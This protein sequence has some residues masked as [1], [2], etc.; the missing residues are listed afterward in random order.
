VSGCSGKPA[1]TRTN[2]NPS[3]F[4]ECAHHYRDVA[5]SSGLEMSLHDSTFPGC[6]GEHV[7]MAVPAVRPK[8]RALAARGT[9]AAQSKSTP[10]LRAALK[11]TTRRRVAR[12][13]RS[14][15]DQN[16][17]AMRELRTQV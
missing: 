7:E 5:Q 3:M 17:V 2:T 16:F 8:I 15:E 11:A 14:V 10:T 12:K 9:G 4:L 6:I 13:G 1:R